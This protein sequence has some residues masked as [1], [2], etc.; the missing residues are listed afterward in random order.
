MAHRPKVPS[1]KFGDSFVEYVPQMRGMIKVNVVFQVLGGALGNSPSVGALGSA[2][3]EGFLEYADD[4]LMRE[5][6]KYGYSYTG[7]G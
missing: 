7:G 4:C 6:L 2:S 1:G 5:F 3:T